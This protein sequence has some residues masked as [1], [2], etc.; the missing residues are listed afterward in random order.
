MSGVQRLVEG[1]IPDPTSRYRAAG[2]RSCSGHAPDGIWSRRITSPLCQPY[3]T[4]WTVIV[5]RPPAGDGAANRPE[6]GR[7][8]ESDH[9]RAAGRAARGR[10]AAPPL[11]DAASR[12]R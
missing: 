5:A 1:A 2:N 8:D 3:R 12:L 6:A 11:A 9:R 10:I 7:A 4:T